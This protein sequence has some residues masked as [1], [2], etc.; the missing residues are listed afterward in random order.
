MT[1]ATHNAILNPDASDTATAIGVI[2]VIVPTDVPIAVDTKQATI[3]S[4]A[5]ANFAGIMLNIK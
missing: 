5:T 4:T 3:K 1:D 2:S